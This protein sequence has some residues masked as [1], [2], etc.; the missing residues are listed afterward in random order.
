[1]LKPFLYL[2]EL[3]Q[4]KNISLVRVKH[5]RNVSFLTKDIKII[6][7]IETVLKATLTQFKNNNYT[8]ESKYLVIGNYFFLVSNLSYIS[9]KFLPTWPRGNAVALA[10]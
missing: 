1:M 10:P 5:R 2:P 4:G 3:L 8:C 6:V 9:S 7:P